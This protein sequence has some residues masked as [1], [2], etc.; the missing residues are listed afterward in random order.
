MTRAIVVAMHKYTPFGSKFYDPILLSF[1]KQMKKYEGEYDRLYLVDS[2]W[3]ITYEDVWGWEKAKIVRVDPHLRYYDAYKQVL[4]QIGEGLVLFMDNDQIIYKPGVIKKTFDKLDHDLP[5]VDTA[6]GD[7]AHVDVVSIYDTIG[8][9]KTDKLNGK[10]KFCPYWFAARKELLMKYLNTD[11][12][13]DMPY[14]ETLGYLT[15]AMLA[16]RVTPYEWEEDKTS[17][18]FYGEPSDLKGKDLG[19]YHI[20]AGSTPAYLLATRKYGDKN[21]YQ[22]YINNQPRNEYLR[23]MA[24]YSYMNDWPHVFGD[25]GVFQG[26]ILEIILMLSDLGIDWKAWED[27]LRRFGRYHGL[28]VRERS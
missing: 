6:F 8:T 15:E 21:T 20:R 5:V 13:P 10:N 19:Y 28:T 25:A 24:W 2:N 7:E 14:C 18:W 11:W 3:G 27:Y 16:N 17:C 26:V 9:Y 4:P 12:A 1:L 22:D 23:Q